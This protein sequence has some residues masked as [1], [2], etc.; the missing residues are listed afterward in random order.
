MRV[1]KKKAYRLLPP[2]LLKQMT[3]VKMYSHLAD[4]SSGLLYLFC[5]YPIILIFNDTI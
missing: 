5:S 3:E 4:D 2:S 1:G